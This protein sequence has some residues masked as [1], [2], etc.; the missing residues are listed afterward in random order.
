MKGCTPADHMYAMI[1]WHHYSSGENNLAMFLDEVV[2]M[3]MKYWL[4]YV[5]CNIFD[6]VVTTRMKYLSR[7][8]CH[9]ED[10]DEG[11]VVAICL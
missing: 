9:H 7:W 5:C 3:R 2:T 11:L 1:N 4:Q 10:D 6:G 8:S